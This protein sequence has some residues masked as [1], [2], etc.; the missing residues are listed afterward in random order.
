VGFCLVEGKGHGYLLRKGVFT[1]IDVPGSTTGVAVDVNPKGVVVGSYTAPDGTS[2][3]Y[4][5]YRGQ[6]RTIDV[7]GG[8]FTFASGINPEGEIVGKY[9]TVDGKFH[10]FLLEYETDE[11]RSD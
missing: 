6:F 11:N 3:G 2:H 4:L 5:W 9:R 8:V 1:L 10:G 7:P